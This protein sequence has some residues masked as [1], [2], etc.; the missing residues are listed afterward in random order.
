MLCVRKC[1]EL[2]GSHA[3]TIIIFVYLKILNEEYLHVRRTL[4]QV[5]IALIKSQNIKAVKR[6]DN[7]EIDI[8]TPDGLILLFLSLEL[9]QL[10]Y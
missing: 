9:K 5:P 7:A 6:K 3:L 2:L 1:F 4:Y 10:K 8:H